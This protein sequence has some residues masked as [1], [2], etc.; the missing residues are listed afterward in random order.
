VLQDSLRGFNI[1]KKGYAYR[2]DPTGPTLQ[3]QMLYGQWLIN[4]TVLIAAA[5]AI[6]VTKAARVAVFMAKI[7]NDKKSLE[8]L[9]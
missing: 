1:S 4:L 9:V 5:L 3:S 8:N 7:T 2:F 6:H